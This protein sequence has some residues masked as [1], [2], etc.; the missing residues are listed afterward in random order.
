VSV[1]SRIPASARRTLMG[2]WRGSPE[3]E[4]SLLH[5]PGPQWPVIRGV[6]GGQDS[7]PRSACE[8]FGSRLTFH[9][10]AALGGSAQLASVIARGLAQ[11]FRFAAR[12]FWALYLEMVEEPMNAWEKAEGRH[13]KAAQSR[14]KCKALERA[15]LKRYEAEL[16][17]IVADWGFQAPA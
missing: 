14:A 13:A 7:A 1:W 4:G 16:A 10:P 15:Y 17:K 3:H 12:R 6:D 11:C 5:R 9:L 2:Y 8:D